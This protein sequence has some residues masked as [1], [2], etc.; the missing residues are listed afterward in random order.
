M[1]IIIKITCLYILH[2]ACVFLAAV[3][4][5]NNQ[6]KIKISSG[7]HLVL[8]FY[9]F[10]LFLHMDHPDFLLLLKQG[11]RSLEDHTRLFLK[12]ANYTG[13]TDDTLCPFYT[14]QVWTPP[15]EC[16]H[17]RWVLKRVSPLLW[18]GYWRETDLCFS[19]GLVE[20][21]ASPT[22]DPEPN[23]TSPCCTEHQLEPTAG[24]EPKPAV[25]DEPSLKRATEPQTMSDQMRE[26]ATMHTTVDS[27]VQCEGMEG[28]PAHCTTTGG[29]L[30]QEVIVCLSC[31]RP[32]EIL[33]ALKYLSA[34]NCPRLLKWPRRSLPCLS[35][36]ALN[37]TIQL[38]HYS[39]FRLLTSIVQY[40]NHIFKIVHTVCITNM[41]LGQT[42][43][44]INKLSSDELYLSHTQLYRV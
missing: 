15:A 5:Q 41:N 37:K 44:T 40:W 14:M 7:Y 31:Y 10:Y 21:L 11:E 34:L 13:Y 36:G 42:V 32:F 30:R 27:T 8:F 33:S 12:V 20:D 1:W 19:D 3:V 2:R 25:N 39:F 29:E 6:P 9:C 16:S 18:S 38:Q 22:P 4:L 26:P 35:R 43:H 28:S 23:L 24:R 17:R